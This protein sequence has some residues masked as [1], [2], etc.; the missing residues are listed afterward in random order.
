M[1]L[2]NNYISYGIIGMAKTEKFFDFCSLKNL[3]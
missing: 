1:L 2:K 3:S